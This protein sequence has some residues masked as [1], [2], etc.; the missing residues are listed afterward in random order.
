MR[1]GFGKSEAKYEMARGGTRKYLRHLI[2]VLRH[3]R[4]RVHFHRSL[5]LG[6]TAAHVP[7]A[8]HSDNDSD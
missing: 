2:R 6:Y 7:E 1:E 8:I 5:A 4:P 3:L